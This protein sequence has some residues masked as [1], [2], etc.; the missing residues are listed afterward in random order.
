[1]RQTRRD[2]SSVS[3]CAWI[4]EEKERLADS[5]GE[6]PIGPIEPFRN[7]RFVARVLDVVGGR[8]GPWQ[9]LRPCRGRLERDE[10]SY[11]AVEARPDSVSRISIAGV[12]PMRV[13]VMGRSAGRGC[14]GTFI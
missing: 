4:A 11:A 2:G 7:V 6:T 9:R 12:M 14:V 10:V 13:R 5:S 8:A 3:L 1:M